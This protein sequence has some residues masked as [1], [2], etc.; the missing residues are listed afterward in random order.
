MNREKWMA[1]L[2]ELDSAIPLIREDIN[3]LRERIR[4]E[5]ITYLKGSQFDDR[6]KFWLQQIELEIKGAAL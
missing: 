5:A 2:L 3:S 6:A 1:R 4:L